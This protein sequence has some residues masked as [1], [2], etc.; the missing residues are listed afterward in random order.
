M[1]VLKYLFIWFAELCPATAT[2]I[3][4]RKYI[5]QSLDLK[6]PKTLNEKLQWLKLNTYRNNLVVRRCADKLAVREFVASKGWAEALVELLEVWD[7]VDDIDFDVLPNKFVLKCNHGSGMNII[8]SD[9]S[10]FDQE[11]ARNKLK[12]WMCQDF[13]RQRAELSYKNMDKK[14]ICE[15]YI[16]TKDGNPPQDYKIFCSYGQPKFLFI[17]SDRY[18]DNTKFDY[19]T[20]DWKWLP[21]K[22]GHPNAGD[23]FIKPEKYEEMLKIASKLSEEFPIVRVDLYHGQGKVI[24][25]EM[26]F[27]HFGGLTP[28]EPKTFDRKFGDMLDIS[29]SNS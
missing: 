15:T 5:G 27:L 17:A 4:F 21:V 2:K 13:G 14:I 23:V 9:K 1:E 28:F 12:H 20:I 8:C 22:N 7:S 19:Y 11:D 24:F 29:R 10:S 26:T 6:N 25:G 16:E 3:L 18:D